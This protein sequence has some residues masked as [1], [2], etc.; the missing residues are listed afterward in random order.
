MVRNND[1]ENEEADQEEGDKSH[2]P[3]DRLI[4]QNTD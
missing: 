4:H 3:P 2:K 1:S